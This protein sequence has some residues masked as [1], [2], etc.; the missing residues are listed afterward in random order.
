[1]YSPSSRHSSRNEL[2][3]IPYSLITILLYRFIFDLR[4]S[5]ESRFV[6][7][8]EANDSRFNVSSIIAAQLQNIAG[9]MDG[10]LREGNEDNADE[11]AEDQHGVMGSR[12]VESPRV[13]PSR[14]GDTAT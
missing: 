12:G 4:Q 1:M 3:T 5:S 6:D 13:Y 2:N 8:S 11:R 7:D 14:A 10:M 9:T